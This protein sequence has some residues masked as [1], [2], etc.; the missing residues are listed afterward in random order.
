MDVSPVSDSGPENLV[1]NTGMKR[2]LRASAN[3]KGEIQG[4]FPVFRMNE[5][6]FRMTAL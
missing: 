6:A 3:S 2:Y 5:T 4:S 1:K